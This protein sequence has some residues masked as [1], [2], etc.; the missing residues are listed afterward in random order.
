MALDKTRWGQHGLSA[1]AVAFP[2]PLRH[3]HAYIRQL[4]RRQEA[5]GLFLVVTGHPG[6]V[7]ELHAHPVRRRPLR[8][9][10]DVLLM[11]PGEGKPRRELQEDR[12]QLSGEAQR[13]RRGQE[14]LPG[15]IGHRRVDVFGY[16]LSLPVFPRAGAYDLRQFSE[17]PD[18][19][20]GTRPEIRVLAR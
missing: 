14:P 16:T 7:A 18:L 5:Q 13:L 20:P 19:A 1:V 6:V 2:V 12:A 11:T 3:V 10:H 15:L 8:A 4:I 9:G 17:I